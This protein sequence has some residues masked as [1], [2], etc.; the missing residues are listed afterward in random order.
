V[1]GA[2]ELR[3]L[4][5]LSKPTIAR[6]HGPAFAGGVGLVA[7]CDIAIGSVEASFCL[8][9]VKLGLTPATISPYVVRAMGERLGQISP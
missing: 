8:S 9:E 1:V 5:R 7:A 4:D 3:T 6:V 2:V